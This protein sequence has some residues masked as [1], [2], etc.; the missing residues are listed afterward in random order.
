MSLKR[1][2][3]R[4]LHLLKQVRKPPVFFSIPG[5][6]S[7]ARD[8]VLEQYR[9]VSVSAARVLALTILGSMEE[10]VNSTE[11]WRYKSPAACPD[12]MPPARIYYK[13]RTGHLIV[14]DQGIIANDPFFGLASIPFLSLSRKLKVPGHGLCCKGCEKTLADYKYLRLPAAIITT[15]VPSD[16]HPW[17]ISF[18][19]ISR[20]IRD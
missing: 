9:L 18:N 6:Y 3:H 8:L 13:P 7:M 4:H 15:R 10:V 2:L 16:C 11:S 12:P 20:A 1:K 17:R 14:P 5:R 19:L